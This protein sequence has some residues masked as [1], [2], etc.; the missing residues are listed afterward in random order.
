[1]AKLKIV[2]MIEREKEEERG[3]SWGFEEK[4]KR[5]N[6]TKQREIQRM[7]KASFLYCEK[8]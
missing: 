5:E 3:R 7:T 1:M 2:E 6:G 8:I 4:R